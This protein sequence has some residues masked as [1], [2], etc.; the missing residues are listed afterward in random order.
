[1]KKT[2]ERCKSANFPKIPK[3]ISDIKEAFMKPDIKNKY[4]LT[5]DAENYFYVDTI[6][7]DDFQFT[8]FASHFII[9]FV[10]EKIPPESR[11]FL[12]D[13]TFDSLPKSFYQLLIIAI[14][15]QNKVSE[16]WKHP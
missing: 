6:L 16:N 8:V 4:G 15:Y 14:E 3:S 12:L 10:K 2:L 7:G 9:N 11:N 1:M 13:G 5:L